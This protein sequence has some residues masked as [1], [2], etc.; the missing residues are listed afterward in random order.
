MGQQ[1][2]GLY[3]DFVKELTL[4][5]SR[6]LLITF[7]GWAIL[8]AVPLLVLAWLLLN[9]ELN[10]TLVIPLQ[11]FYI[12]TVVQVASL[13]VALVVSRVAIEMLE[14]RV[15][16]LG[17]GFMALAGIFAIHGLATPGIL[18]PRM[19]PEY[20][21]SVV[22]LSAY[23]SLFLSALL[24]GAGAAPLASRV[25]IRNR[26]VAFALVAAVLAVVVIYSVTA[27]Q[28]PTFYANLPIGFPPGSWFLAGLTLVLLAA[29]I[30][31]YVAAY[32]LT[33]LPM[34]GALVTG[35]V[36]LLESQVSQVL[37]PAWSLAWWEYHFL[38]LLGAGTA[39]TGLLVSYSKTGSMR[40]IMEG[41][42]ELQSLVE[43]ELTHTDTI[44]ALAAA[45]EAKDPYT[46]G[47]TVRVAEVA[48][49]VGKA[50]R[51][52][53]EKLRVLARAGLL[54]D[55]G[56]LGIPDAILCKPGPLTPD[57][58]EVIKQHP[59]LGYNIMER[60]GSMEQ[61]ITTI[62]AHHEWI[63]GTGYPDGLLAAQ[64]PIEARVLAVAD[65]YDS[66]VS[67][68]PY[69]KALPRDEVIRILKAE[70]GSHLD[71]KVVDVCLSLLAENKLPAISLPSK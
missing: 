11:H 71:T 31:R 3:G 14:F 9:P 46:K 2:G 43:V 45:T 69:R 15:L 44:A 54:H 51:L 40:K 20:R 39:M 53:N 19:G 65:M 50:M 62:R 28:M 23:L 49:A 37:S 4:L 42:F 5:I 17:M 52:P 66:L 59:L 26:K 57:E 10:L 35:F 68:R 55:I 6:R 18:M 32:T 13:V 67:T 25:R 29:V 63:D 27:F 22:G 21:G 36:F 58:F 24:F 34:Q 7:G 38:M 61:E 1:L 64:I 47:H 56:K 16:L 12:V 60:I 70:A 8:L 41:V 33:R 48:V 30:R